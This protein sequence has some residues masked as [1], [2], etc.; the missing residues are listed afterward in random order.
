MSKKIIVKKAQ[1]T[2]GMG[3]GTDTRM[4]APR[5]ESSHLFRNNHEDEAS[6]YSP[7][8]GKYKDERMEKKKRKRKEREAEMKRLKHIRIK[9]SDLPPSEDEEEEDEDLEPTKFDNELEP[10][11]MTGTHGNFGAMTS[12]ANQARG[13]GFAG[14]HDF[15]M[16]EPMDMA[17]RLLKMPQA[18]FD[19]EDYD[20]YQHSMRLPALNRILA[21][22]PA[23]NLDTLNLIGD[24]DNQFPSVAEN[25]NYVSMSTEPPIRPETL[26]EA[27]DAG[28]IAQPI[29]TGDKGHRGHGTWRNKVEMPKGQRGYVFRPRWGE[30]RYG[31]SDPARRSVSS[32]YVGYSH[33]EPIPENVK[34]TSEEQ[35]AMLEHDYNLSG[36]DYPP[37]SYAQGELN[38][39]LY[40]GERNKEWQ[41]AHQ[42]LQEEKREHQRLERNR[43]AAEKRAWEKAERDR[44]AEKHGLPYEQALE[45]EREEQRQAA[46]REAEAT[47]KWQEKKW[48]EDARKREEKALRRANPGMTM[49][50]IYEMKTQKDSMKRHAAKVEEM[51]EAQRPKRRKFGTTRGPPRRGTMGRKKSEPMDIAF[52]LLKRDERQGFVGAGKKP[53]KKKTSKQRKEHK[54][55]QKKWRP[56]T[57]EFKRPPGGMTPAVQHRGEQ[58]P[59]CVASRVVR[60]PD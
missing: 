55:R 32:Q 24:Q 19:Q 18:Q 27:R 8:D 47:R 53:R 22:D 28:F 7:E 20:E 57:G 4:Y 45:A 46:I 48:A 34:P 30:S 3:T 41:A 59:E 5:S 42:D 15:A 49:G 11:L 37:H 50:Q 51:R 6:V 44:I 38:P 39:E 33:A 52:Q 54:E 13:P 58:K 29:K 40:T 31:S 9:P 43:A 14:G 60:K 25:Y 56:S 2:M 16:G 26:Q 17:W 12:M 1:G 36:G 23:K 21:R 35:S 10:S